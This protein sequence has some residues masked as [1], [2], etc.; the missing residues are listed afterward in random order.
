[1]KK[2]TKWL[3]YG[4]KNR[5]FWLINVCNF[6]LNKVIFFSNFRINGLLYV[7][8]KGRIVI[9][10]EFLANSGKK[11]NPIGGDTILR[12]ITK[13]N[14]AQ[15]NIGNNVGISNCTVICFE[16]IEIGDHVLLGG[17]IKIWDSDFHQLSS[18]NRAN[19]KGVIISKPVKIS[20]NVFV[21]AGSIILKG[22]TIGERSIIGAGSVV[23]KS[24]PAD[25]IWAGNPAQFVRR[26]K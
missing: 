7:S 1:M 9:G 3:Y 20:S 11:H 24:I 12:L 22:V 10:S 6:K 18:I 19:N 15:I 2:T 21:G 25:E 14:T 26:I 13:T 17:G 8:N 23:S 5:I 16:K 4:T